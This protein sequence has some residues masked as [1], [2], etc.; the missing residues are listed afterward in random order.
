VKEYYEVVNIVY[1]HELQC[2]GAVENMGAFASNVRY[3]IEDGTEVEELMENDEFTIIDEIVFTHI[4]ES[5]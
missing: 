3:T 4:E 1:I 5:N 2:Y